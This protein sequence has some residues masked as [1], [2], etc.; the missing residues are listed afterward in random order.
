MNSRQRVKAVLEGKKPDR[1]PFNFWMDRNLM[2]ELDKKFGAEFRINH[3][4][5]DIQE[6]YIGYDWNCGLPT[7][8]KSDHKTSWQTAPTLDDMEKMMSLVFPSVQ[9]NK[10][11]IYRAIREDRKRLPDTAIMAMS[12]T[13]FEAFLGLR[14]MENAMMD[15]YDYPDEVEYYI[16]EGG[17]KLTELI[18]NLEGLDVDMVYLAGDI[19][20]S[21]GVMFNP[22]MLRKYCFDPIRGAINAAHKLGLKVF[23]HTD[24][25]VM[26]MLPIFVEYGLNGINPL[27]PHLNDAKKFKAEYGDKLM[28]YGGI[29]NCFAIPDSDTDGVKKHIFSQFEI[30]GKDGGLIFSSHDIPD[31][32]KME[33]IDVMVE[34]IKSIKP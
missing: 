10:D 18:E 21:K 24:G 33:N 3:Y 28:L 1:L 11:N 20:S 17:K 15:F 5:A 14:T 22:E 4:G 25:N 19:C 13:P 23:Y 29:D 7:H 2:A 31:T 30:L 34:T 12:I 8:Y 9:E 6:S 32:V 16:N 27:Q 26:D